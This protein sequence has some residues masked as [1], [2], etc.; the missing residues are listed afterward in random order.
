MEE[1][2]LAR[3]FAPFYTTKRKGTGLG[4]AI[5][6]RIISEHHGFIQVESIPKKGS[7]VR[8]FLRASQ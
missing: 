2:T 8:I 5:S 6:H 1:E 7:T 4:L 3:L